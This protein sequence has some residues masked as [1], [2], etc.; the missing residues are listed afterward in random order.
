[1]ERLPV[2]LEILTVLPEEVSVLYVVQSSLSSDVFKINM[3]TRDN[4]VWSL[5]IY[6]SK[7]FK[8]LTVNKETYLQETIVLTGLCE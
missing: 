8:S 1:M 3:T 7:F 2:L 5:E 6:R 4:L